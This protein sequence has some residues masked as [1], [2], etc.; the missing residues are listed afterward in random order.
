FPAT[1]GRYQGTTRPEPMKPPPSTLALNP[2]SRPQAPTRAG[3]V[4]HG[5]QLLS[6]VRQ[7][8]GGGRDLY[9]SADGNIYQRR[10]NGWYRR[11]ADGNWSFY[12][13]TQGQTQRGQKGSA[14]VAQR[15]GVSG[16]YRAAPGAN[17][18]A[19]RAQAGRDRI[20]NAGREVQAREVA[21]LER[22]YY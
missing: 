7:S 12:A 20:P 17:V 13:P 5:A 14:T 3:D 21:A 2:Y 6:A 11:Q 10:N 4:P 19:A 15:G 8:P 18:P 9:A 22:Q 16:A 1:Y